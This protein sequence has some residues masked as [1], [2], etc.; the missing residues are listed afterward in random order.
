MS[1]YLRMGKSGRKLIPAAQTVIL[2]PEGALYQESCNTL[3]RPPR[4]SCSLILEMLINNNASL[5]SNGERYN[6][7]YSV[8]LK[9]T[10]QTA[11]TPAFTVD[12]RVLYS[13]KIKK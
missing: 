8:R 7:L 4:A 2:T 1:N 3:V 12:V 6:L 10:G 11:P 5:I 13:K 9:F